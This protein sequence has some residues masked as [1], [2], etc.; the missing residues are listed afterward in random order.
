MFLL[1]VGGRDGDGMGWDGSL[2]V[3]VDGYG[4]DGGR[5]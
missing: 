4:V 3:V 5:R 2:V 1:V